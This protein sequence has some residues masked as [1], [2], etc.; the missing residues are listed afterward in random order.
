M[1]CPGRGTGFGVRRRAVVAEATLGGAGGVQSA[2]WTRLLILMPLL[3][4][5]YA[6]R[7]TRP[8]ANLRYRLAMA[9]AR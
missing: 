3:P 5:V 8:E 7:E 9:I 4:I 2:L 1:L 6:D